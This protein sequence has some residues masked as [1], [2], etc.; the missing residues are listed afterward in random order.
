MQK[1]RKRLIF[2][3]RFMTRRMIHK[4]TQFDKTLEKIFSFTPNEIS[5]SLSIPLKKASTIYKKLNHLDHPQMMKKDEEIAQIVTIYDKEY[6][7]QL[8]TI[9]DAPLV[10]YTLGN[11]ALLK[12]LP[13]ISV[14]GTRKPT[15]EAPQKLKQIVTPIIKNDWVI[16]SGLAYGIDSLAHKL[17]LFH[18]GKTITVLGSGLNHIYPRENIQLFEQIAKMGLVVTEYPPDVPPRKYHFPERNRIISGLSLATLVIE[19]TEKSGTLITV[20]QALDQGRE[21]YAVPGSPLIKQTVGCHQMIQDGAK[22]IMCAND[23]LDDWK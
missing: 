5:H 19:A 8:K 4:I 23:I 12:H 1:V 7:D 2:L 16:V 21:V 14:I 6:P 13:S 17:A 22:L 10:L 15:N 11:I 3:H 9:P 20:D 18:K